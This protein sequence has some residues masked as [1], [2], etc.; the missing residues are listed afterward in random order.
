MPYRKQSVKSRALGV[1][2]TA[3]LRRAPTM[4]YSGGMS[5]KYKLPMNVTGGIYKFSEKV[6]LG[7]NSATSIGPKINTASLT[8]SG[9]LITFK[10]TDL[11]NWTSYQNLFDLFKIDRVDLQIIP[12]CNVAQTY[13]VGATGGAASQIPQLYIAPNRDFFVPAPTSG[14]DLLNDDGALVLYMDKPRTLTIWQPRAAVV[15]EKAPTAVSAN[16]GVFDSKTQQWLSTGGNT[17]AVDQ[18]GSQYYGFR[19]WCD[20]TQ[21]G[22]PF[23][24][25]IIATYHV[26]FKERD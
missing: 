17:Q 8:Q 4:R 20:N 11:L 13:L 7:L 21:N 18:S 26:S 5:K 14:P 1:R 22:G 24:P 3:T 23:I 19:W 16:I 10:V 6:S 25:T 15:D 2:R 12:Q 9:G